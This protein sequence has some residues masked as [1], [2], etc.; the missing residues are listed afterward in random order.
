MEAQHTA[1]ASVLTA[2]SSVAPLAWRVG[3]LSA[4]LSSSPI[5]SVYLSEDRAFTTSALSPGAS[6]Q[7]GLIGANVRSRQR[8]RRGVICP[9][10][11]WLAVICTAHLQPRAVV[12]G[13]S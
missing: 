6:E 1:T 10:V 3:A 7:G 2:V 13:R 8:C 5:W 12:S 4:I 9:D 11:T